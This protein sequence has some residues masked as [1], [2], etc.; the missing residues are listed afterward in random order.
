[1]AE[2][3]IVIPKDLEKKY[4][5][6][7]LNDENRSLNYS[8]E[9]TYVQKELNGWKYSEVVTIPTA[10]RQKIFYDLVKYQDDTGDDE[11]AF[12][13]IAKRYNYPIKAIRAIGIEGALKK[14]QT[15]SF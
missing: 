3:E 1:M 13:V 10:T 15:P 14:W 2:V 7:E 8:Q 4:D 11:G 6:N 5:A 12:I 9:L